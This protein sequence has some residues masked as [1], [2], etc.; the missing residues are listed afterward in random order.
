MMMLGPDSSRLELV[1]CTGWHGRVRTALSAFHFRIYY[2]Y[3]NKHI[4]HMSRSLPIHWITIIPPRFMMANGRTNT[5]FRNITHV[6]AHKLLKR[7]NV[8][9]HFLIPLSCIHMA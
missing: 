4:S 2:F 7:E 9:K 8:V 1:G 6:T 5:N 3:F